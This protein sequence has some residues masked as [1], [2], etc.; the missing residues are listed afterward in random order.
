MWNKL[1]N[2]NTGPSHVLDLLF[3]LLAEELGLDDHRLRR[4]TA[5]AQ[6]FEVTLQSH[7]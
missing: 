6:H 7:T 2:Q 5:L 3:G 1:G 4:H